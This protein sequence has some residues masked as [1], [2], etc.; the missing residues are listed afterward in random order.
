[1]RLRVGA[2]AQVVGFAVL[3]HAAQV[4]LHDVEIDDQ[5]GSFEFGC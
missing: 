1:M 3:G 2:E 4:A 5:S